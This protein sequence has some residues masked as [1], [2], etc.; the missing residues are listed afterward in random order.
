MKNILI[1]GASGFLGSNLIKFLPKKKFRFKVLIRNQSLNRFKKNN[2]L[3]NIKIITFNN[4]DN[5]NK[6]L[7]LIKVDTIVHCA[8][9]YIKKHH[10]K[11][12]QKLNEANINYGNVLL[13]NL[14]NLKANKFINISTVWENYNGIRNKSGNLYAAY[15]RGFNE[16]IN[17]YKNVN[18]KIQF[19]NILLADTFGANDQRI[20]LI[21]V[22]KKNIKK[23]K[24]TNLISKNTQIN[25]LNIKDVTR[26]IELV[27]NKNIKPGSYVLKNTKYFSFIQIINQISK[28]NNKNVKIKWIGKKNFKEKILTYK[29]LPKWK[30]LLSSISDLGKI[31][32]SKI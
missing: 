23:N 5:L 26:G 24:Q 2:S 20:K 14:H 11:D 3:N 1:T 27:I 32:N 16:I 10:Y 12:L 9:H 6:K 29:T 21:N 25:L 8:T 31:I 7:K 28:Q 19:Y 13:E 15:K 17:F 22:L 18:P 30:P 4:F